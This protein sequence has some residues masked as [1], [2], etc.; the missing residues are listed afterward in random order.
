MANRTAVIVPNYNGIRYIGNCLASL[1]EQTAKDFEVFVVDNGSTD[2]SAE[3]AAEE[4]P[5]VHMIRLGE[6]TGFTG[7]VN[8]GLKEAEHFKYVLLLNNDTIAGKHFVEALEKAI[9][10]DPRLF[11]CQASMRQMSDPLLCNDAGDYY[12]ALGWAFARGKGKKAERYK[13]NT[14]VFFSCAGAAVYRMSVMKELG[15][16]D[17]QMFAYLEDCDLGWRARLKGYE[18]LYV[19]SAYVL[20]AGSG[21]SGSRYN[22]FK[23]KYSSRNSVYI[24]RKNMPLWQRAVNLPFHLAGFGIKTFFFIRKGFGKI[25]IKG[26]LEGMRMKTGPVKAEPGAYLAAEKW[27]LKGILLRIKEG[28]V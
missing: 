21:S 13:K 4:F 19:P 10:S 1:R 18:N 15:G 23:V 20:H 5:E 2:G 24:I 16:L 28:F 27:L 22:E 12:T 7:A 8:A 3:L 14:P 6:N 25:Y 26:L 17:P 11:S 9:D